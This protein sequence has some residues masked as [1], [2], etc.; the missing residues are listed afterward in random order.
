M[1]EKQI[2]YDILQSYVYKIFLQ[3]KIQSR[4]PYDSTGIPSHLI[5]QDGSA[6]YS[7]LPK[8]H[9]S[10]LGPFQVLEGLLLIA[11]SR[12]LADPLLTGAN[13]LAQQTHF[14]ICEQEK[15]NHI[16]CLILSIQQYVSWDP[17]LQMF[18]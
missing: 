8:R 2:N 5:H 18:T 16:S 9:S 12:I 11:E 4:W 6:S 17:S 3:P 15:N 14:G 13:E 1:L 7:D 10:D